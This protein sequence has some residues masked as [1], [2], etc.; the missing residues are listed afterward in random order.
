MTGASA[1]VRGVNHITL[2]VRDVDRA[3]AF[4]RD[5]LGL[6]LRKRWEGGAY[7]EAG[8]FWICLSADPETRNEPHGDYTHIAF[9]VA[10]DAFDALSKRL[11]KA[12]APVWKDNRSEGASHYFLD[13]DGHKLEI[14]A[15]TLASR[16]EAMEPCCSA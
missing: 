15:G 16:L 13:P 8:A 1:K 14:H 2:A 11:G 5:I 7:L 4:Y 12:G 6:E 3:V 10:D 9:D